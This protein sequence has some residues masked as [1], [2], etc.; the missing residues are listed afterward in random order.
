MKKKQ[1]KSGM[2]THACDPGTWEEE[3]RESGV[4]D[5]LLHSVMEASLGYMIPYFKIQ[6][7]TRMEG[8][9]GGTCKNNQLLHFVCC[10]MLF[11]LWTLSAQPPVLQI[12]KQV[13]GMGWVWWILL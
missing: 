9:E 3:G 5:S 12:Q 4:L 2:A 8:R 11:P 10:I 7:Q 6:N 13:W 1:I